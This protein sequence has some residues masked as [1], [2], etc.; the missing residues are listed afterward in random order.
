MPY[1]NVIIS[2]GFAMPST[3]GLYQFYWG[4]NG[5]FSATPSP[6]DSGFLA[7]TNEYGVYDFSIVVF[8]FPFEDTIHVTSGTAAGTADITVTTTT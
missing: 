3:L 8:G 4:P 1:A 6:V 5:N 2:G 7:Q